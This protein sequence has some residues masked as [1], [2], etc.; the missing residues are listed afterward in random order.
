MAYGSDTRRVEA[1]LRKIAEAH[2]LVMTEPAP[3]AVFQGFGANSMDFEVWAILRD[4]NWSLSAK[5]DVN[6]EIAK[7]FAEEGIEIPFPQRDVWLHNPQSLKENP[8]S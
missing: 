2:P 4:V 1:V 8:A 3:S 7:R 6:H 5:S